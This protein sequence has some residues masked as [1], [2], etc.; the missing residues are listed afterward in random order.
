VYQRLYDGILPALI[1]SIPAGSVFFGVKDAVKTS[2]KSSGLVSKEVATILSVMV[3][4]IPY[5]LL[6]NPTEVIKTREQAFTYLSNKPSSAN[7][8]LY[9][10]IQQIPD[11]YSSYLPNILY[12]LPADILKFVA[13]KI[14]I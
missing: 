4:N 10:I 13:C 11:L 2:L 3:A 7:N 8:S 5:W 14:V 6:K 12:A 1:G 9:N